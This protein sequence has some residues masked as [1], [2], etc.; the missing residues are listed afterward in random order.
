MELERLALPLQD[1]KGVVVPGLV[2]GTSFSTKRR[3]LGVVHAYG[4]F[5]LLFLVLGSVAESNFFPLMRSFP[6]TRFLSRR[7]CICWVAELSRRSRKRRPTV[8]SLS[9]RTK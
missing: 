6:L 9:V 8:S 1:K 4:S 7:T 2:P 5:F 3:T